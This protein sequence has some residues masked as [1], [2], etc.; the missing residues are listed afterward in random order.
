M[1]ALL[2]T[3]FYYLR[4]FEFVLEWV[5]ARY[6]DLL[7]EQE[8]RFVQHFPT[9]PER[10]RALLVRLIMRK[11]DHFRVSRLCYDEIGDIESAAQPLLEL[12]WLSAE[13]PIDVSSLARL[14]LKTELASLDLG[15]NRPASWASRR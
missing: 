4:N 11:G 6:D 12:S 7:N 10:S 13:E 3:D 15:L 2:A 1:P 14:L 9:L 5:G 8:R